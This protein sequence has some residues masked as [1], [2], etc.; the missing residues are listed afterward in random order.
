MLN[1]YKNSFQNYSQCLERG[2]SREL[3]RIQLPLAN[4]TE[5]YWK[6]DLHNFFHYN[7]LRDDPSHA[8]NEIV[9]LAQIMYDMVKKLFPVSCQ[10]FEDYQKNSVSLNKLE[11]SVLR[12]FLN[13]DKFLFSEWGQNMSTRDISELKQ[14]IT[15]IIEGK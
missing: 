9:Q 6:I 5:L 3:A 12:E 7:Q 11:M 10:A 13:I 1:N 14:K 15:T 4:Y 2:L 8:Q